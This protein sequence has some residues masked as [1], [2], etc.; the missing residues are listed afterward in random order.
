MGKPCLPPESYTLGWLCALPLELEEA[1][2]MLDEEH[3]EHTRKPHETNIYVLGSIKGHNVVILCLPAGRYGTNPAAACLGQLKAKFPSVGVGLMVGIAGGVPS[4]EADIRL[5]DVVISQPRGQYGGVVQ[6]DLGKTEAGGQTIRTGYLSPPPTTLLNAVSRFQSE[7]N[8]TRNILNHLSSLGSARKIDKPNLDVLY[9]ATYEHSS[10]DTCRNCDIHKVKPR[11]DRAQDLQVFYGVVASGNQVIKDGVT[12]DRLSKELGGVLCFEMEAAGVMDT[13][14]CLVVRGICDYADS[15][16]NKDWQ[17]YAAAVAA[18]C[19]K[20]L[21]GVIPPVQIH[22][23]RVDDDELK[24]CLDALFVTDHTI[25]RA[26]LITAKGRRVENTCEWIK[27]NDLYHSWLEPNGQPLLWICGGPG[28]GKTMLSIYL[29]EQFEEI[30]QTSNT[31]QLIYYF[32]RHEDGSSNTA[33]AILRTLIHQIIKKQP[34]L[35]RHAKPLF[36]TRKRVEYTLSSTEALWAIFEALVRDPRIDTTFCILDG[37][38][39]CDGESIKFLATKLRDLLGHTTENNTFPKFQLLMVSREIHALK[40]SPTIQIDPDHDEQVGGDIERF[41][42][43]RLPELHRVEGFTP[44][45]ATHVEH[46]RLQKSEGT[47][48]WVGFV[49]NELL[50]KRTC[51]ELLQTL[52]ILPKGLPG[53]YAR[54][55]L[56]VDESQR[57]QCAHIL[58]WVTIAARPLT[59][60][61]LF[62]AIGRPAPSM[63]NRDQAI[64]DQLAI[65]KPLIKVQDDEVVLIHQ[66]IRD[67]LLRENYDDDPILETFRVKSEEAH[68][69][70]VKACLDVIEN[71][72]SAQPDSPKP[73]LL[74]YALA[75]GPNHARSAES[76]GDIIFDFSRLLFNEKSQVHSKWLI[77][78]QEEYGYQSE[79]HMASAYGLISWVRKLFKRR[80]RYSRSFYANRKDGEGDTPLHLSCINGYEA[81]SRL[82][83]KNGANID[84]MNAENYTPLANAVLFGHNPILRLLLQNSANANIVDINGNTPLILAC[85]KRDHSAIHLLLDHGADVNIRPASQGESDDIDDIDLERKTK[86][87]PRLFSNILKLE[88]STEELRFRMSRWGYNVNPDKLP[89][90]EF[91]SSALGRAIASGDLAIFRRLPLLDAVRRNNEEMVALLLSYGADCNGEDWEGCMGLDLAATKGNLAIVKSLLEHG[92]DIRPRFPY[93][94]LAR[95]AQEGHL[96]VVETL[97]DHGAIDELGSPRCEPL[98]TAALRGHLEVVRALLDRGADARSLAGRAALQ[99]TSDEA[100]AQLLRDRG[101]EWA[102]T[103]SVVEFSECWLN[104]PLGFWSPVQLWTHAIG[105]NLTTDQV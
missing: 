98:L 18:A 29:S 92:A 64:L 26:K 49:M 35:F 40:G 69:S 9:E 81:V 53:V 94:P 87:L 7:Q 89:R 59:K 56:Q 61:E 79:L 60:Y 80:W 77:Y 66:S 42:S 11:K 93:T 71:F 82:L 51:T 21:L 54:I 19:A 78:M 84:A 14:P 38:D 45:I 88:R 46:V 44:E 8:G 76:Y 57:Q 101:A 1:R 86:V 50:Q 91:R 62:D 3:Q 41:I 70:I 30:A 36:D 4:E 67:Y 75:H 90:D 95:S 12:R 47:F 5:G 43:A 74:K 33:S 63:V 104:Y 65:C 24:A 58:L 22:R 102:Y 31:N 85:L 72:F 28:K 73:A 83:I 96:E 97:L 32:C 34:T 10:G 20:E 13:L 2:A 25:D 37:L 17:K 39:E 48:L 100:V 68:L 55:L 16:K 105:Q 27:E 15:H 23:T 52:E 103:F 99:M 6:Y